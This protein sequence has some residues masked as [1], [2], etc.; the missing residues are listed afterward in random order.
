MQSFAK[1]DLKISGILTIQEAACVF[2][3]AGFGLTRAGAGRLVYGVY[4]TGATSRLAC[5]R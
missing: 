2:I 1:Y 5:Q 3:G 4:E